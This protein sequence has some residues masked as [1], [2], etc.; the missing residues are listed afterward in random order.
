[1]QYY[2][3][4]VAVTPSSLVRGPA[5]ETSDETLVQSIAQGDRNALQLLY[6][7]HNVRVFR[8]L[9]RFLSDESSAEDLVTE[10]FL[11]VWRQA[12]RFEA[13]SQVST[14]LLAI[15]RNKALSVLRRRT[16]DEL[17][18]EVAEFI[19]DPADTPEVSIEKKQRGAVLTECLT[20][21]SPAHRANHV[22]V[23][24]HEV[25]RSVSQAEWVE[26]VVEIG[27]RPQRVADDRA[28]QVELS[29]QLRRLSGAH[30]E[31]RD[32]LHT[33]VEELRACFLERLELG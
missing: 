29:R 26:A 21:L 2:S 6:A 5:P 23:V 31:N 30:V 20:Q 4:A 14:W 33:E 18:E 24:E 13:R 10:V 7:R 15:A 32:G 22:M 8:F 28:R 12:D 9:L 16:T 1:M 11:D 3:H 17:D 27:D 19:E 25:G